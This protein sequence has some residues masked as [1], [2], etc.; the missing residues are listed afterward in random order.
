MKQL[1]RGKWSCALCGELFDAP[2]GKTPHVRFHSA[3]AKRTERVLI[4]DGEEVHRCT[5]PGLDREQSAN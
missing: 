2:P 5:L 3:T 1:K 4:V